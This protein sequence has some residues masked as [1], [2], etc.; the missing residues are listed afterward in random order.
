M[1]DGV[2]LAPLGGSARARPLDGVWALVG[3]AEGGQ[4]CEWGKK[5]LGELMGEETYFCMNN[6][7]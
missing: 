5:P 6:S 3:L 2:P 1:A 7:T 4:F